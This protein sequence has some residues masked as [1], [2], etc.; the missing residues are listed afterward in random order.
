MK[1]Y[2]MYSIAG[3]SVF[4]AINSYAMLATRSAQRATTVGRRGYVRWPYPSRGEEQRLQEKKRKEAEEKI[5]EEFK[6]LGLVPSQP[7]TEFSKKEPKNAVPINSFEPQQNNLMTRIS[8]GWQNFKG[9][10][11]DLF[12]TQ[13]M[14]EAKK[15]AASDMQTEHMGEVNK[16]IAADEQAELELEKAKTAAFWDRQLKEAEQ[17]R[18][19]TI[20][21][22]AKTQEQKERDELTRKRAREIEEERVRLSKE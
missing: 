18:I 7:V 8:L 1:K 6:K 10:I 20:R 3:V 5:N 2:V 14:R 22:E 4:G 11:I 21:R 15:K 17:E 13:K 16:L 12:Q 19:A 9:F